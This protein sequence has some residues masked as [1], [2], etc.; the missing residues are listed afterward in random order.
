MWKQGL[1]LCGIYIMRL[2]QDV[3]VLFMKVYTLYLVYTHTYLACLLG[4]LYLY[5]IHNS[6]V[7][8]TI[9]FNSFYSIS[10][11]YKVQSCTL[12]GS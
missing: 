5:V 11:M 7:I 4:A 9:G 6:Y 10:C 8:Q 2:V 3:Y 12:T 1:D